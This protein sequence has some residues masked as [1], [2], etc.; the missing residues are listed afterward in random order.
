MT[1]QASASMPTAWFGARH[2]AERVA[3]T[4]CEA[5][6]G[7]PC[8]TTIAMI[9]TCVSDGMVATGV[10]AERVQRARDLTAQGMLI[11]PS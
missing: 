8:K 6:A 1:R 2:P 9:G 3:C 11:Q 10:H 5:H 4:T 7:A